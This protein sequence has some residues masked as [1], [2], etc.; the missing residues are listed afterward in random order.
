MND[1]RT[2]ERRRH[3]RVD[4]HWPVTVHGVE[5]T[6]AVRTFSATILNAS[7]SG[8]LLEADITANLWADK[9]LTIDLPADVGP[10]SATVRRFIEYGD[11]AHKTSRW[12]VEL[13]QLTIQ[14][15][16][17]WGRFVYTAAREAGHALADIVVRVAAPPEPSPRRRSALADAHVSPPHA[18]RTGVNALARDWAG[19]DAGVHIPGPAVSGADS[20]VG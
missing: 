13:T 20:A 1:R 7:L 15:R 6:G 2:L 5:H 10:T 8:V 3:V 9:P 16:A 14:Q 17:R 19:A 12:G 18:P 11:D 4:G